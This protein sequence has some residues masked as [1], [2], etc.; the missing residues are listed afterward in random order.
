MTN[1]TVCIMWL[2]PELINDFGIRLEH[3]LLFIRLNWVTKT[4]GKVSQNDSLIIF[5]WSLFN[6]HVNE[7]FKRWKFFRSFTLFKV[8]NLEKVFLN[9]EIS[10][11]G[12]ILWIDWLI[13]W[14]ERV[15]ALF[16]HLL[17]FWYSL[18]RWM[19]I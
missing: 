14:C 16:I 8:W 11:H 12:P 17:V 18:D 15:L 4:K 6:S 2:R 19:L 1:Y 5:Y 3:C 13:D 9:K 7:S 10:K